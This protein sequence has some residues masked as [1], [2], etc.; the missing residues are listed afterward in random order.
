MI[1]SNGIVRTMDPSLPTTAALAIA[2]DR[3]VGGVGVHETA[4][5]TPERVDLRGRC[6]LP[7]FSDSHVHFPTW[8]LAR[9]DVQLEGVVS[10][11]EAAR[12]RCR[13]SS[14]GRVDPGP[15]LARRSLAGASDARGARRGHRRDTGRP[16]VEGL[17]LAVAQQRGA[18]PRRR[19]PRRAGRCR[20][21]RHGGR[22]DRDPARGVGVA[23]P[24]ESRDDLRGRV[25]RR[26]P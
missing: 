14:A 1:L 3:I 12:T 20:G 23:V 7:A 18:R 6:V 10:L 24:R 26:D 25:R 8:S 11:A 2:G 19:R 22:A 15:W 9:Q 4:L 13:A 17:P 16:L 21:A 5:P